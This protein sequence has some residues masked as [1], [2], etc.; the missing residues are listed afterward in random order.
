MKLKSVKKNSGASGSY[1]SNIAAK[2]IENEAGRFRK[3]ARLRNCS[4]LFATSEETH[5][6]FYGGLSAEIR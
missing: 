3:E 2:E 6:C 1:G 5:V 4:R